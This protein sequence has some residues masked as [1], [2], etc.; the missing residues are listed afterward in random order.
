MTP[1]TSKSKKKASSKKSQVTVK[2]TRRTLLLWSGVAFFAMTWMFILGVLVGRDLSPVRF[3]VKKLK[4]ELMALKQKAL[5]TEKVNSKNENDMFSR[6]PE[7][8]FYQILTD[9]KKEAS[10]KFAKAH[11]RNTKSGVAF[12]KVGEAYQAETEEK[13]PLK[14]SEVDKRPAKRRARPAEALK[15]D[16][17]KGQGGLAIQ[18]ASLNDAQGARQMVYRLRRRGYRAYAVA[19]TPNGKETYHRVRVGPFSDS[20]EVSQTAARLKRDRFEVMIVSE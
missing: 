2:F 8:D 11:K 16:N 14:L 15:P 5:K 1:K 3:D 4:T 6:D 12:P 19:V 13:I 7:L 20:D 9:K 17:M 18:V 10:S